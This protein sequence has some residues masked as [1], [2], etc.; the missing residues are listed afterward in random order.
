MFQ[1]LKLL[2]N[3]SAIVWFFKDF[4]LRNANSKLKCGSKLIPNKLEADL[5][6]YF[7]CNLQSITYQK[8]INGNVAMPSFRYLVWVQ[9]LTGCNDGHSSETQWVGRWTSEEYSVIPPRPYY[10]WTINFNKEMLTGR[11]EYRWV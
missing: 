5:T 6:K 7:T 10:L 4:F 8:Q 9:P 3:Y 11:K 2:M 1:S